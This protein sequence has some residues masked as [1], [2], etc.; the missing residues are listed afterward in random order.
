MAIEDLISAWETPGGLPPFDEVSDDDFLPA[1]REAIEAARQR[2]SKIASG[3]DPATFDNVIAALE[4]ADTELQRVEAVFFVLAGADSNDDRQAIERE[5]VPE[6]V[7]FET[8]IAMN[9]GLFEKISTVWEQREALGLDDEQLMTLKR[10]R[11]DFVNSGAI[12]GEPLQQRFAGIREELARLHVQFGQN[13]LADESEWC[14]ELGESDL[15]GLPEFLLQ[16]AHQAAADRQRVGHVITL[17]RSLIEPFLKFAEDRKLRRAAYQAWAGRGAGGGL[18]DNR[19][20]ASQ[21]ITLRHEMATL[22][23]Y[24][25]YADFKLE[26]EMAKTPDAARTLLDEVWVAARAAAMADAARHQQALAVDGQTDQ[27]QPWDWRY[28]AER[29]R[30]TEHRL[31]EAEIKQYFRLRP[32]TEAAFHVAGLLFDLSFHE[33]DADSYHPDCRVWEVRR[34]GSPCAT[35]IADHFARPSKQSGAWCTSLRDQH[36]LAEGSRPIVVNVCNFMKPPAGEPCLLSHDDARTL[37]HEFGHALHAMLSDVTYPS[38]SGTSVARDFVELPSQL[39]ENWLEV[40]EVLDRFATHAE[41]GNR[42]PAEL[43]RKLASARNF[44]QGFATVEY[45]ASAFVDLDFHSGE[46]PSD[47]VERQREVLGELGMPAAIGMRH[48][49]PHF[50]HVFSGNGYAA[51][52]YSYLWADVL[53]ADA[54]EAFQDAGGPF[55]R[56]TADRLA[57]CILSAGGGREPEDL[58]ISFRGK[59][60]TVGALLRKRGFANHR[61]DP[62]DA[63]V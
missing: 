12:L 23:G 32:L 55:C 45:L 61:Q 28:Y 11:R 54:F 16:A 4:V 21:I 19:Q 27:L 30:E 39:F 14:M 35:F 10:C 2:I 50:A 51:G 17:D 18:T 56:Q 38:V 9:R 34:G 40:D 13:L 15:R 29:L 41:T 49:T 36:R 7:R 62:N 22:L 33:L 43:R 47:L 24:R 5:I 57:R 46:P 52:Y 48:A 42:I 8:E 59:L 3:R 60:P 44:D 1:F 20:I 63:A 26:D 31:D 53:A 58:Y 6:L 37:F 25:S